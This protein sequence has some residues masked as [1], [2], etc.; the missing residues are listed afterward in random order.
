[1]MNKQYFATIKQQLVERCICVLV[2]AVVAYAAVWL[3]SMTEW[4]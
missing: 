4:H 2:I 3:A 1:M